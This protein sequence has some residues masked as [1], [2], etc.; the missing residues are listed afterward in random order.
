MSR[1]CPLCGGTKFAHWRFGFRWLQN[2]LGKGDELIV[3]AR[4]G[5]Y[6]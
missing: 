2:Q 1:T 5:A 6:D 3:M 4:K